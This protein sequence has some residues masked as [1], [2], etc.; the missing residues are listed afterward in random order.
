MFNILQYHPNDGQMK[1][2][3][4]VNITSINVDALNSLP[5]HSGVSGFCLE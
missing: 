4:N 5:L 2:S 3:L 1:N